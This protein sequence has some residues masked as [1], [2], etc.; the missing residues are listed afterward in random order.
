MVF[1]VIAMY[2]QIKKHL[3]LS[4]IVLDNNEMLPEIIDQQSR[5]TKLF[6]L[7]EIKFDKKRGMFFQKKHNRK[8]N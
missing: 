2:L 5:K 3:I 7:Q 8:R 4:K 6:N 1:I